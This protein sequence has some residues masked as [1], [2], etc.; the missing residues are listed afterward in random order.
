MTDSPVAEVQPSTSRPTTTQVP[1]RWRVLGAN[2][3]IMT[4]N[5]GDRTAIAVAGPLIIADL[6][7]SKSTFGWIL[8]AFFLGYVPALYFGGWA[9]DK[10][11]P[12]KV[13]AGAIAGWSLFTALT[14]VGFNAISLMLVRF[15]F[16]LAEGPQ[17]PA[18]TKSMS[19]WFP[20]RK[21]A[22]AIGLSYS[23]QPLGGAI[24]APVVVALIAATGSWRAPF[25]AF[26]VAGALFLIGWWVTVRD[27][28]AKDPRASVAEVAEMEQDDLEQ[29]AAEGEAHQ[30]GVRQY[31]R[32]P[33]VWT[34]IAAYFGVIWMLYTFLNW[35]PTFISEVHGVSLAGLAAA[36]AV[37]WVCGSIGLAAS[38]LIADKVA[39]M[40]GG[41]LYFSRKWTFVV[42]V[43]IVAVLIS[44]VG[45]ASTATAAVVLMGGVLLI[46]YIA[47]GLP[48]SLIASI[49][50]KSV[51]GTVFGVAIGTANLAGVINPI[52]IGYL[53]EGTG[54]WAL[55]F[56]LGAVVAVVPALAL[57]AYHVPKHVE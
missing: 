6:G 25:I 31:L 35:F 49:V 48:Q 7:L 24:G 56:G 27:T 55:V 28:P 52:V 16:G 50:P 32:N 42:T 20:R 8:S 54:N 1:R 12:R 34:I 44:F 15:L 10:F 33:L 41:R 21:L 29:R 40:T 57:A 9:A 13:M 17:A 43:I 46:L 11:G 53:A 51:F 14:A 30:G 3:S 47:L 4:L 2:F 5:Y 39:K 37:P 19:N 26:G 45:R 38:G 22:T 36:S 23:A 18:T